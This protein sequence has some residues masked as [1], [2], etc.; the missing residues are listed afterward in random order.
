M[1]RRGWRF[2]GRGRTG[3]DADAGRPGSGCPE[4][5][6][7]ASKEGEGG[8][9]EA[10]DDFFVKAE[11]TVLDEI[12]SKTFTN[13]HV[14]SGSGSDRGDASP[15]LKSSRKKSAKDPSGTEMNEPRKRCHRRHH[16]DQG[17][18]SPAGRRSNPPSRT[19]A[20]TFRRGPVGGILGTDSFTTPP[21]LQRYYVSEEEQEDMQRAFQ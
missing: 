18:P 10:E 3:D 2:R 6:G 8:G 1:G 12:F 21:A 16:T 11:H 4:T 5:A 20:P 15:T 7:A 9:E 17:S 14:A 13:E 19:T